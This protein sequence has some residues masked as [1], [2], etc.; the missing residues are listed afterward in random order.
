M[1]RPSNWNSPTDSVRLPKHAIPAAM[2]LARQLDNAAATRRLVDNVQNPPG[3]Y[4]VTMED[5]AK[6]ESYLIDPDPDTPPEAWAEADRLVEQLV[7]EHGY[8]NLL[9]IIGRMAQEWGKPVELGGQS[10]V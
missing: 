6:T 3:P 7:A 1:G 8:K 5:G 2:A 4:L 10:D 9:Y